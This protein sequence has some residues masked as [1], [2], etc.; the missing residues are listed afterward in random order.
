MEFKSTSFK[1]IVKTNMAKTE[2]LGFDKE[3]NAY[4]MNVHAVPEKGKANLEIIK[5]F[6]KELKKDITIISGMASRQKLIRII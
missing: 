6:K 4:R 5:F 2:I 3:K 1:L